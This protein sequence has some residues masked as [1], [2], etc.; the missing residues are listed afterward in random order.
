MPACGGYFQSAFDILLL[1]NITEI[2]VVIVQAIKEF[3]ARIYYFGLQF[4]VAVK[5]PG[6]FAMLS[7]P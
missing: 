4:Q 6:Y 2:A 5:K 3:F 7:T 1:L